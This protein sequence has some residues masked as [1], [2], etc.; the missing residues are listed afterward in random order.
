MY[1]LSKKQVV[2]SE[3]C[4][5]IFQVVGL[6]AILLV[7][8]FRLLQYSDVLLLWCQEIHPV[9]KFTF[10]D[11][12]NGWLNKKSTVVVV[13]VVVVVVI[14]SQACSLSLDVSGFETHFP[15]VLVSVKCG[16]VL[17]SV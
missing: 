5:W 1:S 17:V 6:I 8:I 14:K 3:L 9:Q 12:K 4:F 16:N 11:F 2:V 10:G 13:I 15:N 7:T